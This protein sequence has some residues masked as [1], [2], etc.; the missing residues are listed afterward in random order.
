MPP[1]TP[2][3][4]I[5]EHRNGFV[6]AVRIKL[7]DVLAEANVWGERGV[8]SIS[9]LRFIVSMWAVPGPAQLEFK[10]EQI[11]VE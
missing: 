3:P 10:R 6:K 11:R 2:S 8:R 1:K 9:L 5:T 7:R 4:A